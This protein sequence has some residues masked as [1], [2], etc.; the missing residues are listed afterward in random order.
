[1]KIPKLYAMFTLLV[2]SACGKNSDALISQ[3]PKAV[4]AMASPSQAEIVDQSPD[5]TIR[6]IKYNL[7][8]EEV[9]TQ[10]A[11]YVENDLRQ[12]PTDPKYNTML[13]KIYNVEAYENS[14]F[15]APKIYV[16]SGP[17]K[18]RLTPKHNS[19]G[20]VTL[21]FPV[22]L[23]DAT[24]QEIVAPD[25]KTLIQLP[26][27]MTVKKINELQAELNQRFERQQVLSSLP[28]CPKRIYVKF[29]NQEYDATPIEFRRGDY[30]QMNAP[31][32]ASITLPKED[33]RF[34]LETAI[35]NNTAAT[36]SVEFETRARISV[37][38]MEIEFDK[39]KIF[40][41]LE[42]L[43]K[44]NAGWADIEAKAHVTKVMQN[45][46]LKM[47][48]VGEIGPHMDQIVA[49]AIE[50]FFEKFRPD[51]DG[52]TSS[53]SGRPV[54]LR[55]NYNSLSD[56]KKLKVEWYHSKNELTGQNYITW[57][58]LNP[59]DDSIKIGGEGR[60]ELT[61]KA[62]IETGL[63]VRA[64]DLIEI[65]PD[66]LKIERRA[67]INSSPSTQNNVVCV[68]TK[69]ICVL[70]CHPRN[71]RKAVPEFCEQWETKCVRSEN[72]WLQTTAYSLSSPV[73]DTLNNP[74]GQLEQIFDGLS[75]KFTWSDQQG[76]LKETTCPLRYFAREGNG[77]SILVR[78][79]KTP[80]CDIFSDNGN[81]PMLH[82]VNGIEFPVTYQDGSLVQNWLGQTLQTPAQKT[83]IPDVSFAGTVMIRGYNMGTSNSMAHED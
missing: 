79:S 39:S 69:D 60:R 54:C 27:S 29:G 25:G 82:L 16:Y 53:C 57:A 58:G 56:S 61:R 49:S 78:I 81:A 51:P 48:M 71:C 37:A 28:G 23:T 45:Q 44:L 13:F 4:A 55:L 3:R 72:R 43:F 40:T 42:A 6:L 46:T 52:Q 67:A 35:Y 26:T 19:N 21:D 5:G 62:P 83:F 70:R 30:C 9:D 12:I 15:I 1:M 75:F 34:L 2:F 32:T 18:A 36:V 76:N 68:E 47:H 17:D 59:L 31:F 7:P 22:I 73:L 33:A 64:G 63:T 77:K 50:L 66:Y 24:K 38:K 10:R 20:T 41:E 80:K 14:V 11:Q 74:V 65:T 8:K